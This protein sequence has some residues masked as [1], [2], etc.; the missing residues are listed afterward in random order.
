MG[1]LL[2]Q[3]LAGVVAA[4]LLSVVKDVA[5]NCYG[6]KS[7]CKR[8]EKTLEGIIPIL[9]EIFKTGA[10]VS[11]H[12]Q[13]ELKEFY[14]KLQKGIELVKNCSKVSRLNMYQRYKFAKRILA[15]EKYISSFNHN[16]GWA[17]VM[18]DLHH[19]RVDTGRRLEYIQKQVEGN[20]DCILFEQMMKDQMPLFEIGSE[21]SY[22][23]LQIPEMP[24][25]PVGLK[26]SVEELKKRLFPQDVSL[27]SVKGMG[28]SGKTTLAVALCSDQQVQEFFKGK[29]IF[30]TVSQSPN[31]KGLLERMWDKIVREPRPDFHN[32]ED[33]RIQLQRRLR[34][35]EPQPILV[36]L[37]DVWSKKD[38]EKL[39]FKAE[40]CKTLI[41]TRFNSLVRS[42]YQYDLQL[43]READALSLFC[44]WTF[45]QSF[46]PETADV[47]LVKQVLA[48]CKGLPLALKVIG[49]S[50]QDQP[51]PVWQSARNKLLQAE[52]ISDYHKDGLLKCMATS[53]D[54]LEDEVRECFLDLGAFPEDRKISVD[55]LLDLWIY[56]HD[57]EWQDAYT[58]LMELASRNLLNLVN[59]PASHSRNFYGSSSELSFVQHDAL[60]DLALYLTK[61]KPLNKCKRLIMPHKE[62]CVPEKW[63]NCTDQPFDARIVSIHTGAMDE[64]QWCQMDFPAAEALVLNFAASE[65][66][67]PSFLRT[68]HKLKVLII[69]NHNSK[70]AKL[71]G[72]SAFPSLTQLKSVRLERVIVPPLQEHSQSLQKL[73]K[74]SLI[75][76]EGSGNMTGLHMELCL[77]LPRLREINFD[78]CSNLEELPASI[79]NMT[80][81]QRLSVRNCHDLYKISD[82]L[83]NLSSLQMLRLYACPSLEELPY[84]ICKLRQLEFLDISLCECMKQLPEALGQLSSLREIDMRECSRVKQLPRSA[85]DLRS[86]VHVICDEKIGHR[87]SAIKDSTIPQLCV[88]VAE[89]HFHLDWLED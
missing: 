29:I 54:I 43:L 61:E 50:L 2:S 75:L 36:V 11:Q 5:K 71:K 48:E 3:T 44:F 41:T 32:V 64:K 59:I 88:E 63:K 21:A 6:C 38:L 47:N 8:L 55:A 58:I 76:C 28:G 72:L 56:L 27:I 66:Y 4:E 73:E 51:L 30:E 87:W 19:M 85:S 79:C 34:Q 83:G 68:M 40:G 53:I 52:S 65:Y 89:E 25:H 16:Q 57:L 86:L 9:D 20:H 14:E 67:L 62:D 18:S 12:R 37:D 17:H 46:I 78:H 82:D 33:A 80:S 24:E 39:L 42:T 69:V 81:L 84:S 1:D 77:N 49:S 45:G 23:N 13:R 22:P 31:L 10:E 7:Y 15:L 70:R 26:I 60:R 35:M 74:L